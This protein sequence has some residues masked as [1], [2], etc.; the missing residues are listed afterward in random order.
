VPE[1]LARRADPVGSPARSEAPT[2][3]RPSGALV[4]ATSRWAVLLTPPLSGVHNMAIDHA[5]MRR[6]ARTGEGVLRIYS[7]QVPTLSFGRH[8]IAAGVYSREAIQA[9]G[10]AVVR[11]PTGGRAV[12][13]DDE[14]TYG[15]TAPLVPDGDPGL[16]P[17]GARRARARALY[18]AINHVLLDGLRRLGVAGA[19]VSRGAIRPAAVAGPCFD[20]A[21]DGEVVVGGRKLVGS[22]QWREDGAV[23]Q[24][25]SM[26]IA[27]HR[28]R[29]AALAPTLAPPVA[30]PIAPAAPAATL[31]ELLG[32][33]P[34]PAEVA[35]ALTGALDD[36]LAAA[37][38]PRTRVLS[39]DPDTEAM[40][41]ALR[42]RYEDDG[43]TWRR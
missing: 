18:T 41:V 10:L 27:D 31:R 29:L 32:R 43:W 21:S 28:A 6:A 12:L 5:L 7:W 40:A 25:G 17:G 9:A 19:L 1:T 34:S 15:V 37:G 3:E 42:G 33:A 35:T 38:A 30:S 23:L 2:I 39:I 26:L 16:A 14:I 8:E 24:H 13:H 22:A 20:T 11:R 36:A 4:V